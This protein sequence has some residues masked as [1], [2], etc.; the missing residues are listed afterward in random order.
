MSTLAPVVLGVEHPE[1]FHSMLQATEY[2]LGQLKAKLAKLRTELQAPAA[3]SVHGLAV[4]VLQGCLCTLH[5]QDLP[6]LC[7]PTA[8]SVH[9]FSTSWC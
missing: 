2:H 9:T 3:V 8:Q 5:A 6:V 4:P 1:S 7:Q